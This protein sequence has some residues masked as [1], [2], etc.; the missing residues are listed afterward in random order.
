MGSRVHHAPAPSLRT[1]THP[2]QLGSMQLDPVWAVVIAAG[3]GVLGALV[4]QHTAAAA[5]LKKA[6]WELF[7]NARAESYREVM[8][9]AG[10]YALNTNAKTHLAF[11]AAHQKALI[12]ASEA[13]C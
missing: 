6:R 11:I 12:F 9:R 2:L 3:I 8:E 13:V 4:A 7:F 5:S 10:T 1:N